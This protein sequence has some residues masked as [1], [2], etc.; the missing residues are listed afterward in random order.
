MYAVV[1]FAPRDVCKNAPELVSAKNPCGEMVPVR[2]GVWAVG[3]PI[4][5]NTSRPSQ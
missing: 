1:S 5:N 3:R 2:R 4:R